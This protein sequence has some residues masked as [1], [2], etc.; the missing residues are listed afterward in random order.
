MYFSDN[1]YLY[2]MCH[3]TGVSGKPDYRQ[4]G[5]RLYDIANVI[6]K[7]MDNSYLLTSIQVGC[8]GL[9]DFSNAY[10][11]LVYLSSYDSI[12]VVPV[13][14]RNTICFIGLE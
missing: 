6:E 4:S 9:I 8:Q 7:N 5:F 14:H 13:L 2:T 10:Q 12:D 11:R 3:K 1:N